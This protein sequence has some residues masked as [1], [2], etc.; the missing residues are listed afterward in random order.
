MLKNL[1][2]KFTSEQQNEINK[3]KY[4]LSNKPIISDFTLLRT[5]SRIYFDE[6]ANE[7]EIRET[8]FDIYHRV[9][10]GVFSILK[11]KLISL[12]KWKENKNYFQKLALRFFE[13]MYKDRFTAP[14]RGLWVMGTKLVNKEKI[15]MPL[16]NCTFI[17]SENINIVKQEFFAYIMDTLMLGIGVGFDDLG[18]GKLF[19]YVPKFAPYEY[20]ETRIHII[21]QLKK[22]I[23]ESA[24]SNFIAPDGKLYVKHELEYN[25]GIISIIHNNSVKIFTIEDSR[26]GWVDGLRELLKSYFY[27]NGYIT[28]FDYSKIRPKGQLLK[29]FSGRSSGSLCLIEL[30]SAIRY[31]IINKYYNKKIDSLFIVDVCNL[32]A[33]TVVAGNVRRSSQ[34][35]ISNNLEVLKYKRYDLEEF[36]YRQLWG[37]SSNNSYKNDKVEK[38]EIHNKNDLGYKTLEM[39]QELINELF[40]NIKYNGE[41]GIFNLN[42]A[43][44]YGR[45]IDGLDYSD[46]DANGTNPCGEITLEGHSS[47]SSDNAY[48]AG[49]ETCNLFE[50]FP[51]NYGDFN[52]TNWK[53]FMQD[54]YLDLEMAVLYT[55]IVTEL[56]CHWT[57]THEIQQRNRRIGISQSGI[58]VFLAKVN[59]DLNIFAEFCNEAY[60]FVKN[61]EKQISELLDQPRSIRITTVKPSGTVSLIANVPSGM[62]FPIANYYIRRVRFTDSEQILYDNLIKSGIHIEKDKYSA[63]TLVASFPVKQSFNTLTRQEI[64]IKFQFEILRILQTYWADNQVSCTITYKKDEFEEL[65]KLTYEYQNYFKG[66]SFLELDTNIYEQAPYESISEELYNE[67]I[68]NVKPLDNDF[69]NSKPEDNE[70]DIYCDGDKCQIIKKIN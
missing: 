45:I 16:Y 25:Q 22:A 37:W 38:L 48:D 47:N 14:G 42:I 23:K 64:S 34:I 21:D 13:G 26:K 57:G 70:T 9:T 10:I 8:K 60:N 49:G 56:P 29:T 66:I 44:S 65:K 36:K 18:A 40:E 5:Y 54:Y 12:N 32:I 63:N 59:Y 28:L 27:P 51:C 61:F 52:Q 35:F 68:E 20:I 4:L 2:F 30:Y 24:N 50:T 62:H 69:I 6:N 33:R 11:D 53:E 67:M 7:N 19:C 43:R 31:L 58:A 46:K 15:G 1:S 39:S 55:K 17:S 41:P 3:Y